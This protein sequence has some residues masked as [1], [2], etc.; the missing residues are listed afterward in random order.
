MSTLA[1][2]PRTTVPPASSSSAR[3][4]GVDVARLRRFDLLAPLSERELAALALHCEE[5]AVPAGAIVIRQG[6]VAKH[7]YFLEDGAV[8]VYR[9]R[10][11]RLQKVALIESPGVFGEMALINRDRVRTAT[12]RAATDLRF[13]SI[14]FSDLIVALRCSS[15]ASG[16][17][18]RQP[19]MRPR[20]SPK[21]RLQASSPISA[22]DLH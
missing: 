4:L 13:F 18:D 20:L 21:P 17:Q 7:I 12:V 9:E 6:Q 15:A 10:L 22:A 2:V 11:D 1:A 8:N 19:P 3:R 14:P 5:A 16:N